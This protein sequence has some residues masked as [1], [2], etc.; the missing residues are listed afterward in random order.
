MYKRKITFSYGM[1]IR[2]RCFQPPPLFSKFYLAACGK[3]GPPTANPQ[4][5]INGDGPFATHSFYRLTSEQ[6]EFDP[7]H[8]QS[9]VD[10]GSTC[11]S[12]QEEQQTV[13]RC[14]LHRKHSTSVAGSL[15]SP[16][17]AEPS[18]SQYLVILLVRLEC[19]I[20]SIFSNINFNAFNLFFLLLVAFA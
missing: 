8:S 16:S 4:V 2:A 7:L 12:I 11:F 14:T 13:V 1:I 3:Q 19:L 5:G 15:C 17:R 20:I 10:G 6:S 18:F 9:A